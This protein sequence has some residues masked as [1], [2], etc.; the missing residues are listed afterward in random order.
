MS[1]PYLVKNPPKQTQFRDRRLRP[2][3]KVTLIV[4]HT[5]ESPADVVGPDT[6]AEN[7]ANFIRNRRDY[8]SYHRLADSDSRINMVDFSKAAYGDGTGSNEFGIHI[9]AAIQAAQ[10][11]KMSLQWREGCIKQLAQC[12]AEAALWIKKTQGVTVPARMITKAESDRGVPGFISHARR[13][14]SRRSDPGANFPWEFFFSEFTKRYNAL[15]RPA[16][17]VKK[18][19]SITIDFGTLNI[20][21]N[22]DMPDSKVRADARLASSVCE[23]CTHQEIGDASDYTA[24]VQTLPAGHKVTNAVPATGNIELH[25]EKRGVTTTWDGDI[26]RKIGEAT[27]VLPGANGTVGRAMTQPRCAKRLA[28]EPI[29]TTLPTIV[30]INVHMINGAFGSKK[31]LATKERRAMWRADWDAIIRGGKGHSAKGRIVIYSGDWNRPLKD[32]PTFPPRSQWIIG[33]RSVAYIDGAVITLPKGVTAQVGKQVVKPVNSD[34]D[35][36]YARLTLSKAA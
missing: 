14:P 9:S 27:M 31:H 25:R 29:G 30:V 10:W 35:L 16:P 4:V 33:G 12:A 19:T 2:G 32:L 22:P 28:L 36:R 3:Q 8:G 13:D 11:S 20:Q 24:I 26:F 18:K 23:I 15:I 1:T 17:G 21:N 6:G 34:H 5:A 7:V